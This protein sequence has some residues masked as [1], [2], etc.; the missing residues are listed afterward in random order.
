M[1]CPRCKMPLASSKLD[2]IAADRCE[3]CHGMWISRKAFRGAAEEADE[4]SGWLAFEL[5]QDA[6]RFR[7][8]PGDLACPRCGKGMPRLAYGDAKVH[9]DV[10]ADCEGAWLDADGLEPTVAALRTELIRIPT[11][12]LLN[13]VFEEAAEIAK[14]GGSLAAEWKHLSRVARLL[15]LRVLTD[16]PQLRRLL[17]S[18]QGGSTFP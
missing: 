11:S 8:V 17:I 15:E 2:G 18:L 16:H 10:C 1:N 9:V 3:N 12:E 14:Q 13:A 5:W 4:D 7:G 6:E